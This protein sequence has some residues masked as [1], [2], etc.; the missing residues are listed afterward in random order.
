[1]EVIDTISAPP[2]RIGTACLLAVWAVGIA[3]ADR[4]E[5]PPCPE[6]LEAYCGDHTHTCRPVP[7][8]PAQLG[9]CEY[10]AECGVDFL[11]RSVDDD[12]YGSSTY[13][14]RATEEVVG[15]RWWSDVPAF[16][17]NT[18]F[19]VTHGQRPRCGSICRLVTSKEWP[20]STMTGE[21]LPP[22]P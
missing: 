19:G 4:S 16:C 15:V 11:V 14:D 8:T 18:R 13:Y 6:P 12:G 3:C 5:G 9:R 10:V 2:P 17:D 21:D 7:R 20:C 1:M 22:C